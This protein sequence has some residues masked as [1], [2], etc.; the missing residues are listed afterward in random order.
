MKYFMLDI[1]TT[2]VELETDSILQVAL[3]EM[4][5]SPAVGIYTAGREFVR[6]LRY[7]DTPE[8]EWI[9]NTH[10][11]LLK[12]CKTIPH[13]SA[14]QIRTEI[15]TFFK[16]CGVTGPAM[17]MGV[18][19]AAFDLP[20]MTKK[21]LLIKPTQDANNNVVGD[22]HYRVYELKGAYNLAQDILKIDSKELFK[23]A[24]RAFLMST[25]PG[26][27]HEALYDCYMQFRTLNGVLRLLEK[28]GRN[29]YP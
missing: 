4:D 22:Y 5:F 21:G 28:D 1:E 19:V 2:G 25:P 7:T 16:Q 11:D 10:R 17:I 26:K 6:T 13:Q 24:E 3:L 27:P 18:N 8:R 20:F 9:R 14:E 29:A 12:R 15:L 23:R